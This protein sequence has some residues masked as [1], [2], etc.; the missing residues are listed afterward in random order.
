MQAV[1]GGVEAD[2]ASHGL[3]PEQIFKRLIVGEL[4]DKTPFAQD[5]ECINHN[6]TSNSRYLHHRNIYCC[7]GQTGITSRGLKGDEGGGIMPSTGRGGDR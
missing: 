3:S 2:I 7:V 1:R 4:L 6:N 5:I